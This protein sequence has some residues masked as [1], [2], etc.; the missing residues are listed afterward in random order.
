MIKFLMVISDIVSY[1]IF[2][3]IIYGVNL[4]HPNLLL[5]RLTKVI[6]ENV[7]A[8]IKDANYDEVMVSLIEK[9]IYI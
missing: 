5:G 6:R 7:A 2:K 8:A 4:S 9:N 1:N 3:V